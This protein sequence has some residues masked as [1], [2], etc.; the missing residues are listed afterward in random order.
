ME[1]GEFQVGRNSNGRRKELEP[2]LDKNVS[3]AAVF[4]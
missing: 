4:S 3:S 2:R 1:R